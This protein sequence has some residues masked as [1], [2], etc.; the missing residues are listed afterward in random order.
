MNAMRA[1]VPRPA[2]AALA[3]IVAILA[4]IVAPAIDARAAQGDA[5][6]VRRVADGLADVAEG[7]GAKS[8]SP[9]EMEAEMIAR[10]RELLDAE[11]FEIGDADGNYI[12]APLAELMHHA[13]EY[14]PMLKAERA[15]IAALEQK[16]TMTG[17]PMEPKIG[18]MVMDLPVVFPWDLEDSMIR[19]RFSISQMFYSYGKRSSRERIAAYDVE[20]AKL[21]IAEAE[22]NLAGEIIGMY[23]NLVRNAVELGTLARRDALLSV[24]EDIA[25]VRYELGK[26]P[27]ADALMVQTERAMVDAMRADVELMRGAMTAEMAG[28]IGIPESELTVNLA[29]VPGFAPVEVADVPGFQPIEVADAESL[30]QAALARHPE[31]MWLDT[32]DEQGAERQKLA[33]KDYH[34]DYEL[35]LD[36]TFSYEMDDR[37][38][39]EVMFNLPVYQDKMQ[40][41]AYKEASAMRAEIPLMQEELLNRIRARGQTEL[42]KL[43]LI[44][45]KIE[46]YRTKLIPLAK[47]TFDSV[48][49]GYQVNMMGLAELV[50]TEVSLVNFEGEMKLAFVDAAESRAKLYYITLGAVKEY[51][52]AGAE[53]A[54]VADETAVV[55]ASVKVVESEGEA[56]AE[57]ESL[58]GSA[59]EI[60]RR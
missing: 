1:Y 38:A 44:F 11:R 57:G 15:R 37:L 8:G 3:A 2:P 45:P 50:Q 18:L 4:A 39:F 33:E 9:A 12:P 22:Y 41:P 55:T 40:D 53:T 59:V 19:E 49:A 5:I 60:G 48:L 42:A 14:S 28:M 17:A 23:F 46:Q 51:A 10:V 34:P 43:R 25:R 52:S 16:V 54:A 31:L 30:W 24:M 7:E 6:T 29:D 58:Q 56:G 35:K 32:L 13:V 27:L 36:Y 20:L 47:T 26:A 21:K